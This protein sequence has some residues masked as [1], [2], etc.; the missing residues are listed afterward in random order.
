MIKI[1]KIFVVLLS[2]FC[3]ILFSQVHTF[4]ATSYAMQRNNQFDNEYPKFEPDNSLV[5]LNIEEKKLAIYGK[6]ETE[7]ILNLING[8]KSEKLTNGDT[9]QV[10][11]AV[12]SD[13]IKCKISFF[14]IYE[15]NPKR[16]YTRQIYIEYKKQKIR[17]IMNVN[18]I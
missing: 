18:K 11:T 7:M 13:G 8:N 12:D 1:N 4:R 14:T 16:N 9:L 3:S 2:F 6:D 5:I 10:Y 17:I 15:Y